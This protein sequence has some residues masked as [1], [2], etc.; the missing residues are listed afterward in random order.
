MKS[1]KSLFTTSKVRCYKSLFTLKI[2]IHDFIIL[3]G[4]LLHLFLN[5][6]YLA[7]HTKEKEENGILEN[8]MKIKRRIRIKTKTIV[9]T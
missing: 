2:V 7:E 6:S 3:R 4:N 1:F 5:T 9:Q 8:K